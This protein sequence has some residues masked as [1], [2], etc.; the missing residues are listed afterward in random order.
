MDQLGD[1]EPAMDITWDEATDYCK[2]LAETMGG[3]ET[4]VFSPPDRSAAGDCRP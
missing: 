1:E 4:P 3:S 2:W